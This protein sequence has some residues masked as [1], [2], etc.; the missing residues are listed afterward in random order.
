MKGVQRRGDRLL[1]AVLLTGRVRVHA[2]L[3][4]GKRAAPG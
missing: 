2:E 4:P 3:G 1:V